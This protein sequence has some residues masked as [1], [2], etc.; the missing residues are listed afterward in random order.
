[1]VDVQRYI[2]IPYKVHGRDF[3]GCDCLGLVILVCREEFGKE[4]PDILYA[5]PEDPEN[6]RLIDPMKSTLQAESVDIP[7]PGD[8]ILAM[9]WGTPHMGICIANNVMLHTSSRYGTVCERLNRYR[10]RNV[11]FYRV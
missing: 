9:M 4:I 10:G 5:N 1:M 11:G 2:Q 7:K 8:L 3:D 6:A